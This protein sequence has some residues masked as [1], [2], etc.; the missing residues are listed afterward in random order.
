MP[1]WARTLTGHDGRRY[2]F[3]PG[4]FSLELLVTGGP[5][6]YRRYEVLHAPE[7]LATWLRDCRLT[8]T[9]PIT[10]VH[11][12]HEDLERVKAL[13]D[14][15]LRVARALAHGAA[16]DPAHVEALNAATAETPRPRLDPGTLALAWAAPVT[17]A[18]VL[19]AAARDAVRTIATGAIRECSADDCRLLFLDTSRS[20]SRRWC[21]MERCGN[22]HKVRTHRVRREAEPL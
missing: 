7:D 6:E 8:T 15:F 17:G 19:G 22:R 4:S 16:P 13:R 9:A 14:A 2:R 11:V 10:D 21:S 5:G 12:T 1:T 20:G 18:Q 3:D